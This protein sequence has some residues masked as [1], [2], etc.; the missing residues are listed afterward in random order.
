M[1]LGLG[2]RIRIQVF[3]LRIL[4]S[5]VPCLGLR[6]YLKFQWGLSK[7]GFRV[8]S[9]GFRVRGLSNQGSKGDNQ[10]FAWLMRTLS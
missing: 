6:V 2:F 9:L 4:G 1:F 5:R 7:L 8:E 10:G 3:G